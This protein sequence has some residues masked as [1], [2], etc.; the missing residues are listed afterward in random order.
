MEKEEQKKVIV[1]FVLTTCQALSGILS[2]WSPF[3][4]TTVL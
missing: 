4:L 1:Y 3:I 2:A